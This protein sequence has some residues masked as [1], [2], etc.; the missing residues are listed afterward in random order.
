MRGIVAEAGVNLAAINYHFGSK[1]GLIRAVLERRMRPLS[2]ERLKLLDE[3]EAKAG[4]ANPLPLEE[5]L[6]ALIRPALWLS[7]DPKKGGAMFMRLLGRAFTDPNETF[8]E[9]L[10]EQLEE[11][12]R[13]YIPAFKRALP[14]LPDQDLFAR[15]HFSVGAMVYT[16][17]DIPRLKRYSGGACDPNDVEGLVR[18]LV[19][20]AAAGLRAESI[21]GG[22]ETNEP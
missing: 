12:V 16:M 14:A 19:A 11:T 6:E 5:V 15:V 10:D 8:Q 4:A 18:Q 21:S 13:R 2:E 22:K 7:R 17:C 3:C 20:F 1:D 9:V